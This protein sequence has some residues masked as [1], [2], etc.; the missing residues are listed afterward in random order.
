MTKTGKPVENFNAADFQVL[1]DGKPQPVRMI[2]RVAGP[3]LPIYAVIVLQLDVGSAP[4]LAKLKKAASLI[5]RY[6]TNDTGTGQPCLSAVVTAADEVEL[7]QSFTADPDTLGETFAKLSATGNSGRL[8]DGVSLACD[9]LS[10]TPAAARRVIALISESRDEQSSA[11]FPD[12]VVKAQRND[13]VIYTISYSPILTAFTQKLLIF[14]HR[15]TKRDRTT[16]L[17]TGA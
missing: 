2:A 6:I 15:L 1:N 4:A 7:A 12:V 5:G 14:H 11:H 9:L 8:I 13:V 3:P 10:K 17:I 16:R